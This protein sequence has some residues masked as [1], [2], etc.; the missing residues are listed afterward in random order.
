[1]QRFEVFTVVQIQVK[2]CWV[3]MLH[4]NTED[5]DLMMMT[6]IVVLVDGLQGAEKDT[7]DR[8]SFCK[9]RTP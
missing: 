5:L 4:H 9:F 7:K 1:M 6:Y 2:V 8:I 3:V